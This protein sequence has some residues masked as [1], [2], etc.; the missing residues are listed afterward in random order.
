MSRHPLSTADRRLLRHLPM[1]L[2]FQQQRGQPDR[3]FRDIPQLQRLLDAKLI[4]T[5]FDMSA[6]AI[7][8]TRGPSYAQHR[9]K[10]LGAAAHELEAEEFLLAPPAGPAR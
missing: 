7:T 1:T 2:L 8:I 3:M 5:S 6:N 10:L 9:R 4:A